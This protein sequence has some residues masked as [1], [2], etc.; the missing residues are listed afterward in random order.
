MQK[1]ADCNS[2]C[3]R[4]YHKEY[5]RKNRNQ[6]L[7]Q[8]KEYYRKNR[9]KILNIQKKYRKKSNKLPT[10]KVKKV[11][12]HKDKLALMDNTVALISIVLDICEKYEDR[13]I[14]V[15]V[16]RQED[17]RDICR[18][19]SNHFVLMKL[20]SEMGLNIKGERAFF[21]VYTWSPLLG[22]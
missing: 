19:L 7:N 15:D 13:K 11:F 10:A 3:H 9:K 14:Y 6:I 17:C 16:L 18:K 2:E 8:R 5:Y 4:K 20:D 22:F 12:V 1:I 21:K